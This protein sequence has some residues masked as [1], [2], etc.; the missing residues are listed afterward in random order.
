MRTQAAV[1]SFS[2]TLTS[3]LAIESLADRAL[4]QFCE[5]T[6]AAGGVI[7]YESSGELR[8]AAAR[9]IR[10]PESVA[11]SD[12][13][14]MAV[15]T[16]ERQTVA[17]PATVR[18]EGVLADFEPREVLVLPVQYKNVTLGV[19]TLATASQFAPDH[20]G[21]IDLFLRG[22]ALAMNNALVHDRLQRLAAVDPLTG[23]YNRRFGLGRLHE[24]FGRAVREK[25]PLGVLLL[26]IDHFKTVNDTHGHL[27]G[28]RALKQIASIARATLREGDVLIRY[29]GDEF[30]AVLPAA[31]ADDVL[32]V[33][34]RL[35]RAVADA[36]FTE[37][38]HSVRLTVSIGGS[39]Y[40]H[41]AAERDTALIELADGA[42]Y[43]AKEAGRNQVEIAR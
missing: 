16:G 38:Q 2:D 26:D 18:V 41:S 35:R 27:T 15:R 32:I 43:R 30:V 42:L 7:L 6:G 11:A 40:P 8:L 4:Q 33:A 29:G 36:S 39:A 19:V 3:Q 12:H 37:G 34:E 13:V 17:I 24:E 10:Q 31:S 21:R 23:V 9:G 28:D 22:L 1:R 14:R 20:L 25:S 5:H